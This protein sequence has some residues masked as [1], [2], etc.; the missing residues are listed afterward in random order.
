ML[1]VTRI[2]FAR[3][4]LLNKP[5]LEE[6]M[7]LLTV[8]DFMIASL[9]TISTILE[10]GSF[11]EI[12]EMT[13]DN[14]KVALSDS[15]AEGY[16]CLSKADIRALS[17][18]LVD[19]DTALG[20]EFDCHGRGNEAVQATVQASTQPLIRGLL[21]ENSDATR[22]PRRLPSMPLGPGLRSA[23]IRQLVSRS[24]INAGNSYSK[25]LAE[26]SSNNKSFLYKKYA[27]FVGTNNVIGVIC[28][29]SVGGLGPR[30]SSEIA[31]FTNHNG[32]N[33]ALITCRSGH[34][35]DIVGCAVIAESKP[36]AHSGS[37]AR[38]LQNMFRKEDSSP[39]TPGMMSWDFARTVEK[40][41]FHCNIAGLMELVRCGI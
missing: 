13:Y 17:S 41:C 3:Y 40:T 26:H 6:P 24:L 30:V 11:K 29:D 34:G 10:I 22:T 25:L 32:T 1:C 8:S 20:L 19:P 33:K 37:V 36:E 21:R 18:A 27:T 2:D 4:L 14:A 5:R 23:D 35:Y 15:S 31:V 39:S 16:P 28:D 9:C 38:S 12:G 7:F